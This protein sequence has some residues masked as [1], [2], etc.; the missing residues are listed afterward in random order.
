MAMP[1]QK[2]G[3]S[4]QDYQTPPELLEAVKRKLGIYELS[5]DLAADENNT[6]VKDVYYTE[7]MNSLQL[8]WNFGGGKWSWCNPPYANIQPW[9]TKALEE[10]AEGAYIAMLLPASVGANW[11]W[12]YVEAHAYTLFLNG[13][14]TF[15]GETTPYPKD[16]A[17]VLYT[18]F[19]Q[20]GNT[21]WDWR[22]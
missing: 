7:A 19:T 12:K 15:V 11:W 1:R 20:G 5:C 18:P 9:V 10:A 4:R 8:S 14:I 16:C 3:A 2:R 13:R 22:T 21:I 17:L 6:V